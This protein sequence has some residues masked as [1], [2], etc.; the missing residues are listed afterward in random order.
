M[1]A[2]RAPAAAVNTEPAQGGAGDRPAAQAALAAARDAAGPAAMAATAPRT[3]NDLAARNRD[4]E[5]LNQKLKQQLTDILNW[6]LVNFKGKHPLPEKNLARLNLPPVTEQCTLHP[7]VRDFLHIS[8]TEEELLNDAFQYT[9]GALQQLAY[10]RMEINYTNESKVVFHVP[11]FPDEG[12]LARAELYGALQ[13]TL[14]PARFNSFLSV[15][16][17]GMDNSFMSFGEASHTVVVEPIIAENGSDLYLRIKDGWVRL[18]EDNT[19]SITATEAVVAAIPRRYADYI[20]YLPDYMQ[21][22]L[23]Q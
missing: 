17:V 8:A 5:A 20:P 15:T 10:E 2:A 19:R 12:R 18:N 6:I 3:A 9:S 4:L 13:E 21:L 1:A 7:D 23:E 14:G 11:T 22:P 16:A